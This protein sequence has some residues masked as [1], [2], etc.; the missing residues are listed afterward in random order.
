MQ[1]ND[2]YPSDQKKTVREL[3]DHNNLKDFSEITNTNEIQI[4][5]DN[6]TCPYCDETQS[7]GPKPSKKHK[8]NENHG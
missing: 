8:Y 3:I 7:I 1:L 2:S 5:T 6:F 4:Q